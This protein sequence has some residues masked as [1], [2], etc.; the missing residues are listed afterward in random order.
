MLR[1]Y[2]GDAHINIGTGEDISI[3]D[4]ARKIMEVTE[5]KGNLTFDSNK[6][7]GMM[8]KVLDVSNIRQLGW[9][10]KTSLDEGLKLYYQ[11][12]CQHHG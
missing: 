11:W 12:Y 1:Y 3:V 7:D 9:Q 6:P 10:H 5:Y 8:R 2:K 4:F